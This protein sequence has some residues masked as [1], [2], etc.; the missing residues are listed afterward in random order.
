MLFIVGG[1]KLIVL[2]DTKEECDKFTQIYLQYNKP[3]YYTAMKMMQNSSLAEEVVQDTFIKISKVLERLDVE[4]RPQTYAY[5]KTTLKRICYFK[6]E[7]EKKQ[8]HTDIFELEIASDFQI[9]EK[10]LKELDCDLLKQFIKQLKP[11]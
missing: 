6:L 2:F 10:L 11:E 5:L 7:Q 3:L 4:K 8:K 1:G 9:E